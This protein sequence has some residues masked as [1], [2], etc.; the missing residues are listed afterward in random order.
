M[1]AADGQDPPEFIPRL[2][3][4]WEKGSDVVWAVRERREGESSSRIVVSRAYYALM[5]LFALANMPPEGADF[6]LLD[7]KVIDAFNQTSERN[8]SILALLMWM[9]FKQT[10]VPYVKEA[11]RGGQSKWTL[12]KKLK[13]GLTRLS[14]SPIS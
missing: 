5:R 7:R 10:D 3:E 9:E 14:A 8:A 6:Y 12:K 4:Q 2:L 11:R 13:L 1:I